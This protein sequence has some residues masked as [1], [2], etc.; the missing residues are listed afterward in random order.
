MESWEPYSP[1]E[2]SALLA[3]LV[4]PWWL[5]GGWALDRFVGHVTRAHA[6]IDVAVLRRDADAVY[7]LLDG[8]DVLIA[9]HCVWCRPTSDEPWRVQL[10]L[11]DSDGDDW[12]YRRDARVRR[13]VATLGDD[14]VLAPE[15]QL[16]W[17]R[18]PRKTSPTSRSSR[19]Y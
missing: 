9:G 3:P 8:W 13:P 1:T 16:L 6:D 15:V 5:A 14:H 2:V 10:L 19:P 12:V 11:E 18:P 7:E 17:G 4:V